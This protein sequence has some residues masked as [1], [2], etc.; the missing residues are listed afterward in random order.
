M[1]SHEDQKKKQ[2]L[3]IQEDDG[4]PAPHENP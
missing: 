1:D 3:E 4:L 2:L